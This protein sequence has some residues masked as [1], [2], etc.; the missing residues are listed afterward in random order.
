MGT[1]DKWMQGSSEDEQI[2][3]ALHEKNVLIRYN[4]K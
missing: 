1:E 3:N 4:D 2:P